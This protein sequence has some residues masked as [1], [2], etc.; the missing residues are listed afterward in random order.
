MRLRH[1]C[2]RK[3]GSLQWLRH[4]DCSGSCRDPAEYVQDQARPPTTVMISWC[5][6]VSPTVAAQKL[7]VTYRSGGLPGRLLLRPRRP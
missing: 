6:G 2:V 4:A 3:D 1:W 7:Q 5:R